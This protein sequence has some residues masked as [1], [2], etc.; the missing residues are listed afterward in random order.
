[1]DCGLRVLP[2]TLNHHRL[3]SSQARGEEGEKILIIEGK[4]S[5]LRL[6][7]DGATNVEL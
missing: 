2:A 4:L 7:T 3:Y 6:C 1:M 5:P